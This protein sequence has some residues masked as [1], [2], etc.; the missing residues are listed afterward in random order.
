MSRKAKKVRTHHEW[1][2][3]VLAG[4]RKSCPSCKA[5]LGEG[6]SVWSWGEYHCA[7]WRT[8]MHFC[9]E[10]FAAKVS[11]PL[12]AHAG[13]CGCEIKLLGYQGRKLPDWLKLATPVEGCVA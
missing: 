1:F 4:G 5:K 3:D 11:K 9:K 2:R 10:C 7:K 12:T 13:G 8:V 6:E